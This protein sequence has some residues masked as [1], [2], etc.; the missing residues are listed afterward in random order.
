MLV[1]LFGWAVSLVKGRLVLVELFGVGC[2]FGQ[3]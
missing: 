2:R 3:G 1:E